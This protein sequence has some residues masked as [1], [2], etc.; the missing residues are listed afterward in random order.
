MWVRIIKKNLKPFL[1]YLW[2]QPTHQY[3]QHIISIFVWK[4]F[5]L[6][7]RGQIKINSTLF[8]LRDSGEQN[9]LLLLGEISYHKLIWPKHAEY[10]SDNIYFLVVSSHWLT[11]LLTHWGLVT[12]IC[13]SKLIINGDH[14]LSASICRWYPAKRALPAMLTHG[15]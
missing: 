7:G 5:A 9:Y 13:I 4:I 12:Y 8:M 11:H 15:R 1:L 14:F 3:W 10:A 6:I 2:H